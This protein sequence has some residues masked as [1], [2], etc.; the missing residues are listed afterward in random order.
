MEFLTPLKDI[1]IE[2]GKRLDAS[3]GS[4]E[5]VIALIKKTYGFIAPSPAIMALPR[6]HWTSSSTTTPDCRPAGQVPHGAGGECGG[7][8]TEVG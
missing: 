7:R 1:V 3:A 8:I 6:R 5:E 4:E 2:P